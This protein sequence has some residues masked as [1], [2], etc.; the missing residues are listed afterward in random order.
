MC[1]PTVTAQHM[2]AQGS[3]LH[4]MC[5]NLPLLSPQGLLH[6]GMGM[7]LSAHEAITLMRS[8][9]GDSNQPVGAHP[10]LQALSLMEG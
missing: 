2:A 5:Y 10:L 4:R 9:G 7:D 8:V 3:V 1:H 6:D